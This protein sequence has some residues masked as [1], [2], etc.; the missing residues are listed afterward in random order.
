ML[1]EFVPN[2]GDGWRYVVDTLTRGLEDAL[3]AI[4]DSDLRAEPPSGVASGDPWEL[5]PAHPLVGPH[6][7]W[8][9]LLGRRTAELHVAL[10]ADLNDPQF[11]PEPLTALDRQALFHGARSLTRQVLRDVVSRE[12]SS[13]FVQQVLSRENEIIE[14]LRLLTA[15]RRSRRSASAA[16]ATSTSGR[17][18]GPGR[19]SSSSTSRESRAGRSAGG[20]SSAP[21]PSTW[22]A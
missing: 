3:A 10:S 7:E 11:A 20:G 8:A 13:A 6:M 15:R 9:S 17:C 18:C 2:E 1:E 4:G 14:R 16:T 12:I 21:P 5:E 22:P 19:T